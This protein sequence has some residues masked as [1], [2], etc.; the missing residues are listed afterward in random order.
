MRLVAARMIGLDGVERLI[1]NPDRTGR[2]QLRM[3]RSRPKA[4]DWLRV[5]RR[6]KEAEIARKQAE[7]G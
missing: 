4:Y 2:S 6:Q 5:T 3:I 1:V 7:V